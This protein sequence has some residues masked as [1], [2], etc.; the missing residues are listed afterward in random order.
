MVADRQGGGHQGG[1]N[2]QVSI[3]RRRDVMKSLIGIVALAAALAGITTAGAQVYPSRQ[4]TMIVP[5]PPGG[6]TDVAARIMAERMRPELG[7]AVIIENIG[8]AGGSIAV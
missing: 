5:F 4:I 3:P 2:K 6:S 1:M 7:Q 8:G